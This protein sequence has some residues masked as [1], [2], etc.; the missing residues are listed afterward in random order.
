MIACVARVIAL[1]YREEMMSGT[2]KLM[3]ITYLKR[4]SQNLAEAHDNLT[5]MWHHEPLDSKTMQK[6]ETWMRATGHLK[7]EVAAKITQLEIE[8]ESSETSARILVLKGPDK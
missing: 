7:N 8:T 3:R 2:D 1:Y 4:A 5:R 6:L